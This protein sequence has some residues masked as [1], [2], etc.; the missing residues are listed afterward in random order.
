MITDK[1]GRSFEHQ[2][3]DIK[4]ENSSEIREDN[5]D[6][7]ADH[8]AYLTALNASNLLLLDAVSFQRNNYVIYTAGLALAI[9]KIAEGEEQGQQILDAIQ[10]A[11]S[12]DQEYV[13]KTGATCVNI[14]EE[15]KKLQ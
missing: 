1:I 9:K 10:K 12:F 3:K 6:V 11:I 7:C 5:A 8:M 13:K 4:P 15:F 14:L 2:S